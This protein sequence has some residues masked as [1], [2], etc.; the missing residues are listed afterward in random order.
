MFP[1][2]SF[3]VV[4]QVEGIKERGHFLA[5]LLYIIPATPEE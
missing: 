1:L 3:E 4:Y 2:D 5:S